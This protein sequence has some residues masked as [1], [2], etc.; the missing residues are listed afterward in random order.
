M[1]LAV[2]ITTV[3][4]VDDLATGKV[5]NLIFYVGIVCSQ[6]WCL[7]NYSVEKALKALVFA[8]IIAMI[9]F[10]L[11][12]IGCLGAGD[13]KLLMVI[14]GF[15]ELK[16]MLRFIFVIFFIGAVIGA[17]MLICK[18]ML[19]KRVKRVLV[20]FAGIIRNGSIDKYNEFTS[21]KT[22]ETD[23]NKIHFTLPILIGL[24]LDVKGII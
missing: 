5:R 12:M 23:C 13:I 21:V 20:Y 10:P 8:V 9:L 24:I 19:I 2:L 3:A 15:Y 7:V 18:G 1:N 14:A 4:A 17:V 16:D 11:F 22:I 6:I